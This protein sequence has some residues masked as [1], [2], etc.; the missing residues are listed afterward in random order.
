MRPVAALLLVMAPSGVAAGS[1][2][3]ELR[4]AR[5]G[6]VGV[7]V[8]WA[9]PEG[10]RPPPSAARHAVMDQRNRAFVPHVL[11][12][13]TGTAVRFPNSDNVRHQVYSFSA[14][15]KF[16]L[17]LYAGSPAGPVVFDKPGVVML[18]C[19]IHDRMSAFIVVVDS[20][21]FASVK[22]GRATLAD[23]PDGRYAVHAW[24]EGLRQ[25]TAPLSVT[26]AGDE[27]RELVLSVPA[28]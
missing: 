22:D 5:G 8:V 9:V 7:G 13:Q 15:K 26:I 21:Y 2:A 17:P 3:V 10:R 11:A 16:Q 24:H 27:R 14:A 20:P 6:P 1:L 23:L 18:G 19:N 25:E 28:R 4:D 12:I